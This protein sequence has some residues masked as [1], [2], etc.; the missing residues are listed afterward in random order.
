MATTYILNLSPT[1]RLE[2]LTPEEAWTGVKPNVKHL[3]IFGSVC[4]KHIPDQLR[5]KLDDKAE[6]LIF[7]GY[8]LTEGY[9]LYNPTSGTT[10]ISR[11]VIVDETEA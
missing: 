11:D 5:R 6:P 9:K 4:Y 10:C 1:K 2:G 3:K 8:N 7:V